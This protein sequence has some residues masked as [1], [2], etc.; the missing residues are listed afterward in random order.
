M[1]STLIRRIERAEQA[2]GGDGGA[3][4]RC[5]DTMIVVG[6]GGEISVTR[7][8]TTLTSEAAER[9]Y[10]EELPNGVCPVCEQQRHKV[11]IRWGAGSSYF[12]AQPGL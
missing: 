3:C 10:K 6:L 4:E 9:F 8:N 7:G 1:V 12:R 11:V 2:D 5:R